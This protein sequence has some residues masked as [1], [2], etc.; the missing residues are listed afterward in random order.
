[1]HPSPRA[2]DGTHI[3]GSAATFDTGVTT[4]RLVSAASRATRAEEILCISVPLAFHGPPRPAL[5]TRARLDVSGH[6]ASQWLSAGEV[7]TGQLGSP[8]AFTDKR[9]AAFE[10]STIDHA[11]SRCCHLCRR[12]RL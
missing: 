7:V 2:R 12:G 10:E 9:T 6:S 5:P 8:S 11:S 4:D 1:M 3:G